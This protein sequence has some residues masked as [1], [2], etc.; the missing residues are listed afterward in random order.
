VVDPLAKKESFPEGSHIVPD[1]AENNLHTIPLSQSGYI[2]I[3]TR[4]K[5]DLPSLRAALKTNAGYIGLIGS[6]RRVAQAFKV[7]LDEGFTE[8]QLEKV[9]APIGLDIGAET[10][11]EIAVS[12]MAEITQHR[13]EGLSKPAEPMKIKFASLASIAKGS[14]H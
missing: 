12:I 6:R 10:P 5:D 8:A 13:R 4:H 3:V 9:N 1:F 2:V 14:E 11:N 7:L